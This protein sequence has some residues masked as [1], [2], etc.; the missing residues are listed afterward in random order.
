VVYLWRVFQVQSDLQQREQALAE[1]VRQAQRLESLGAMAGGVAHD[2]SNLLTVI[3]GNT[4]LIL[5]DAPEGSEMAA[6]ARSIQQATERA[7]AISRQMLDYSGCGKFRPERLDLAGLIASL[8]PLLQASL[9]D[10]VRLV[11]E[12]APGPVPDVI[13]DRSQIQQ[14]L[15]NLVT[16][17]AE[18]TPADGV[19]T[20]RTA[21]VTA[22]E[23]LL[24]EG[25][26]S[27]TLP[28]GRYAAIEVEDTGTGMD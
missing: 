24:A 2:F 19:V 10:R 17:A 14:T 25:A 1:R 8:Q 21:A 16:N 27:A 11:T 4:A 6:A 3:S 13:A 9:P 7:G 20:L 22:D 12:T 5:L 15:V 18:A 26:N 28:A 23:A